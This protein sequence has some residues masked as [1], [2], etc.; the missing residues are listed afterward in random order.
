MRSPAL[1]LLRW[2]FYCRDR[3]LGYSGDPNYLT[4]CQILS[5]TGRMPFTQK[6][7]FY[8]EQRTLCVSR[9]ITYHPTYDSPDYPKTVI[10]M[11]VF[12]Y[13]LTVLR[14]GFI[15]ISRG[16]VM[17]CVV[18]LSPDCPLPFPALILR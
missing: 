6:S 12:T 1:A 16:A 18:P 15:R 17:V 5:H 14:Q 3:A 11:L 4:L 8:L 10:K 9:G 7:D 13:V 2:I